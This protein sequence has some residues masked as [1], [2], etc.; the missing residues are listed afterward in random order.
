MLPLDH[1]N[2]GR[3]I[4][5]RR[6]DLGL[7]QSDLVDNMIKL[8]TIRKVEK[9]EVVNEDIYLH[10]CN[11]LDLDI[12]QL[13]KSYDDEK[14]R[15]EQLKFKLFAIEHD[16]D[17][18]GPDKG[19]EELRKTEIDKNSPLLPTYLF[20]KGKCIA[21]KKHWKKAQAQ[22]LKTLSTLKQYPDWKST[23]VQAATYNELGRCCYYLNNIEQALHY[24]EKGLES[25]DPS[26]EREYVVYHL[27]MSKVIYLEKLNRNEDAF[28]TL[29]DMWKEVDNIESIEIRSS[30][31]EVH[32]T[33][34]SKQELHEKAI[35][36]A[37]KGLHLARVDQNV[38][39][40][41][42]LWTALGDCYQNMGDYYK[43]EVAFRTALKL[44]KK[45]GKKN[46]LV[47]TYTKL[48][49][50]YL[51]T[52]KIPFAQKALQNAV[53]TGQKTNDALKYCNAL[54]ALGDCYMRQNK[55]G[56]AR[57]CLQKALTISEKHALKILEPEILVKLAKCCE[58]EDPVTY[59]KYKNRFFQ[60][61]CQLLEK[62][63]GKL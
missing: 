33:L 24:I 50:L 62:G 32:A 31:Y 2:A 21:R 57:K 60:T 44:E 5:K 20:L 48:G 56:D 8:H 59:E 1:E 16:I 46:M 35:E 52:K 34:L 53:Q 11:K 39:R 22:F 30:M 6:K 49:M 13:S 36:Y 9:G 18:A 27:K 26:G 55:N 54:I 38:D 63:E 45:I 47:S 37:T 10:I 15:E 25:Y 12:K 51:K 43:A 41:F 23:N 61:Y 14:E 42:E 4:R 7:R 58:E 17:M 19:L 29:E 40:A 28:R 3:V